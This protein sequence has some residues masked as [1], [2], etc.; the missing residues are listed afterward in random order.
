MG[1]AARVGLDHKEKSGMV[2]NRNK[3]CWAATSREKV[4]ML[5]AD[6]RGLCHFL[7]KVLQRKSSPDECDG[8]HSLNER[9]NLSRAGVAQG[10]LRVGE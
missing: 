1:F 7:W 9:V 4:G 5:E 8:G 2:P 10:P 6:S 3:N